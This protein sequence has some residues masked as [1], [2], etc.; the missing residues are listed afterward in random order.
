MPGPM[1]RRDLLTWSLAAGAA[2]A[3]LGLA[4]QAAQ[5]Q[6]K[7]QPGADK[8]TA[9]Q[10]GPQ[11]H[12]RWADDPVTCY[13]SHP[14]QKYPYF[15]PVTGPVSGLSLTTESGSSYP[16]HRSLLFACDRV[17]GGNYWQGEISAGQ[18]VSKG[19]KIGERTAESAEI[20]DECQWHLPE[21]PVVMR[22]QR[23][24]KITVV[25]PRL[26]TIDAQITWTAV[27]DTTVT[28]TNHSLFAIR[29]ARDITPWGGGTLVNANG[30]E[31][32]KATFG[33]EAPWCAY[34]GKR[35][36]NPSVV[37]GI[38][39]LDHP[40][41]PWSPCKWFTRDYGFISPTPMNFLEKSWELPAGQSVA[42]RYRVLLFAGDP[43][44]AEVDRIYKEWAA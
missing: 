5:A 22:D 14:T 20:L 41:N 7:P 31:G 1:S 17:N 24:F 39:L 10:F 9:Y 34:Y 44:E 11:I 28:K 30:Q 4:G 43:K 36:G 18:I 27:V 42:L 29:A 21:Q 33:Q 23:V 3:V 19:A 13:R 37:E 2:P 12:I 35:Q 25:G 16:H 15:Y 26:R 40:K 6:I 32:E 8:L 38:A